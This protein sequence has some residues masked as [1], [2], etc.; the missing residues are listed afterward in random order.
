[1]TTL[2]PQPRIVT[3]P[4]CSWVPP[5][6]ATVA[7][8]GTVLAVRCAQFTDDSAHYPLGYAT[9]QGSFAQQTGYAQAVDFDMVLVDDSAVLFGASDSLGAGSRDLPL[10]LPAGTVVQPAFVA[11]AGAASLLAAVQRWICLGPVDPVCRAGSL[12]EAVDEG[13]VERIDQVAM[14]IVKGITLPGVAYSAAQLA[15]MRSHW[16]TVKL[17]LARF[18]VAMP[19]HLWAINEGVKLQAQSSFAAL[20]DSTRQLQVLDDCASVWARWRP[21]TQAIGNAYVPV[22]SLVVDAME[23]AAVVETGP[24]RQL[25]SSAWVH[26]VWTL[27]AQQVAGGAAVA[28]TTVTATGQAPRLT[29]AARNDTFDAPSALTNSRVRALTLSLTTSTA[30]RHTLIFSAAAAAS[31]GAVSPGSHGLLGFAVDY[32]LFSW[33]SSPRTTLASDV[34]GFQATTRS[35]V[36]VDDAVGAV[37]VRLEATPALLAARPVNTS[38]VCAHW[39]TAGQRW[40]NTACTLQSLTATVPVTASCACNTLGI[41]ALV[42]APLLASPG[43]SPLLPLGPR[44]N[45]V[46]PW[47]PIVVALLLLLLLALLLAAY[48]WLMKPRLYAVLGQAEEEPLQSVAPVDDWS[49]HLNRPNLVHV[50]GQMAPDQAIILYDATSSGEDDWPSNDQPDLTLVAAPLFPRAPRQP[51]VGGR[52]ALLRE[53]GGGEAPPALLHDHAFQVAT[54]DAFARAPESDD[55]E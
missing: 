15:L 35:T 19:S 21:G 52:V 28:H 8:L 47:L 11:S 39:V 40:G 17:L 36:P 41:F 33:S 50:P 5:V 32:D 51:F 45:L 37:E 12:Q 48:F 4:G 23:V 26:R 25:V 46:A 1:M 14:G 24:V 16:S 53:V 55:S 13:S 34:V 43:P 42:W 38:L 44:P 18:F 31:I 29:T 2:R 7:V 54:E 10:P 9:R 20:L 30:R 27:L 6:P 3:G 22:L 49:T